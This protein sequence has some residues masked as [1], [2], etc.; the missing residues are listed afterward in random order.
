MNCQEKNAEFSYIYSNLHQLTVHFASLRARDG[1]NQSMTAKREHI[2]P[3]DCHG[4]VKFKHDLPNSILYKR[5]GL[6][7]IGMGRIEYCGS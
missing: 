4:L 2:E 1:K 5:Y 6:A 3:L 7:C